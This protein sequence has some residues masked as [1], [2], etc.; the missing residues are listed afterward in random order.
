LR[1]DVAVGDVDV[2]VDVDV[3]GDVDVDP[4]VG[5]DLDVV[6]APNDDCASGNM[7]GTSDRPPVPG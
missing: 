7:V 4:T 1:T 2:D 5:V 6:S 3:D